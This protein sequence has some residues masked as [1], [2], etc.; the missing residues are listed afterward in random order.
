M[1]VVFISETG[2]WMYGTS[3]VRLSLQMFWMTSLLFS[4]S[5]TSYYS[6]AG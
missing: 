5:M 4:L 1:L 3:E 6:H 2:L